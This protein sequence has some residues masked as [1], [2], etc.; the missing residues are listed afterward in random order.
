MN[1]D[2]DRFKL[3]GAL[4]TQVKVF[5]NKHGTGVGVPSWFPICSKVDLP[6][7]IVASG[8]TAGRWSAG[9][10]ANAM[11][12]KGANYKE[13]LAWMEVECGPTNQNAGCYETDPDYITAVRVPRLRGNDRVANNNKDQLECGEKYWE[14]KKVWKAANEKPGSVLLNLLISTSTDFGSNDCEAGYKPMAE[15]ECKAYATKKRE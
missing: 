5:Y 11:W 8:R 14:N 6:T 1:N 15:A 12:H 3:F 10:N 2:G 4:A 9:K 7:T 13:V